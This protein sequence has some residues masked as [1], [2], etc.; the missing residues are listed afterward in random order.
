MPI[1]NEVDSVI[2]AV[3]YCID[4]ISEAKKEHGD[5][6]RVDKYG[7]EMRWLF[8]DGYRLKIKANKDD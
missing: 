6:I 5:L 4:T 2:E 8:I 3:N 1:Q 7:R